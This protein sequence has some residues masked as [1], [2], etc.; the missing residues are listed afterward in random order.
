MRTLSATRVAHNDRERREPQWHTEID[1]GPPTAAKRAQTVSELSH[2]SFNGRESNFTHAGEATQASL[3]V[4][5]L[6]KPDA[7]IFSVTPRRRLV[8]KDRYR[9]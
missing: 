9:A 4:C 5:G 3:S 8:R 6:G 7:S 2:T 1:Q